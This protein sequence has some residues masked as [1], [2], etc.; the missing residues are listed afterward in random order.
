MTDTKDLVEADRRHF[1]HPFTQMSTWIEDEEVVVIESGRGC[2]LVDTEGR[3]YLDGVS[4]LWC[5]LHGHRVEAIDDAVRAQLDR[6]AH[7]TTLGLTNVPAARLAGR[8]AQIAPPGLTRVFF[9]DS[10]ATAVEAALKLAFQ[11]H[12]QTGM[13][14]RTRFAALGS[15]YHGDTVGSVSIGGIEAM[16][17]MFA[18]LRF[19]VVRVPTPDCLRCPR[20]LDRASCRLECADEAV[21]ILERHARSLAGLVV[22]PLVQ[23]AAGMIVQP[24]GYLSRLAGACGR[25]GILLIAD[26]VA[27]GFGRTGTLFAC[28]Q[29]DVRPDILCLAKGLTGGYLPLAA[30]L[31]TE[32]IFSAFLGTPASGRA[33]LHGHTYTGN[34]LGC[35]A[36]L[37]SLDLLEPMLETLPARAERFG[38]LLEPLADLDH[39]AEIRR[40]GFM[41]GIEVMQDPGSRT[42]YPA[43]LRTGHR[44]I[45]EARSRGVIIRPLGDV[46]VLNPPL[47]I[48][49]EEMELLV[50]VTGESIAAVT[51]A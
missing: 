16:H 36:A 18:P 46:A 34:P 7:S 29:E 31:A 48:S 50:R 37:A 21:Q 35:A 26:E 12:V 3:R 10:G 5:N 47:S 39:V 25:L 2:W 32:E 15:A 22:E 23:G 6:I 44:I 8:L 11:Y 24:E 38:E 30:T 28:T 27:T 51:E 19:D 49:D 1:W 33:F 43:D 20:G 9:S 4:S 14:S 45:N 41:V 42:A 13:R 17:G 40:R